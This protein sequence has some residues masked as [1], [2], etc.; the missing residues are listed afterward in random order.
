MSSLAVRANTGSH[1]VAG[2]AAVLAAGSVLLP[3]LGRS[4]FSRAQ[5]AFARCSRA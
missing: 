5:T 1:T 3:C 4:N 2:A